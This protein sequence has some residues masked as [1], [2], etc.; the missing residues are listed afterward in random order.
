M[1]DVIKWNEAMQ[2]VGD[3]EEFLRE[4]LGDLKSEAQ[5]QINTI[6]GI[7]ANPADTPYFRI[8][9]AA[10][11]IK[12]AAANLFCEKLRAAAHDLEKAALHSHESGQDIQNVQTCYLNLQGAANNY[13]A[14]C[15][16]IGV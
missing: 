11:A 3:D 6:Q 1:D 12:G 2:Q 10:H 16:S 15:Q 5:N 14:F 8:K 4:L 7:I 9:C 13:F